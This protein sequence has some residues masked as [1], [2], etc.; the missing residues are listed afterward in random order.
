MPDAFLRHLTE[1]SKPWRQR[2]GDVEL[3]FFNK[4]GMPVHGVPGMKERA[5]FLNESITFL[6]E[7]FFRRTW[8]NTK[9][10]PVGKRF[11]RENRVGTRVQFCRKPASSPVREGETGDGTENGV[12]ILFCS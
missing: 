7:R 10:D 9:P 3:D 5:P 2:A 12:E 4:I 1:K 6:V 8:T 11:E